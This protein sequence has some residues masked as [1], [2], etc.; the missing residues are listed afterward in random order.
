MPTRPGADTYLEVG[1]TAA[2]GNL[3]NG[4][5]SG[6]VQLRTNK[7]DWTN[8]TESN[9]ASYDGTRTE[10]QPSMNITAYRNGLLLWGKE[11]TPSAGIA[12]QSVFVE[13]TLV[14]AANGTT[15]QI[16]GAKTFTSPVPFVFPET[17]PVSE[18]NLANQPVSLVLTTGTGTITCSYQGG[19][20][21]ASPNTDVDRAFGRVALFREC[22]QACPAIGSSLFITMS[23]DSL[24]STW[25]GTRAGQNVGMYGS[26]VL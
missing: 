7:N 2:A 5:A 18:G 10:Y 17:I 9:D 13:G 4:A 1:F 16:V 3:N 15:T 26:Y 6:E 21:A 14:R 12:G 8:Y 23:Y 19:S 25:F 20:S 24:V 22:D 11:P